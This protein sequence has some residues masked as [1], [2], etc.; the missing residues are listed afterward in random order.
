MKMLGGDWSRGDVLAFIGVLV[1]ILGIWIAHRDTVTSGAKLPSE[2]H[3]STAG[4]GGASGKTAGM[5]HPAIKIVHRVADVSS[6]QVN[7]GC[8][9]N[10]QAKT[11]EVFFGVNPAEIQARTECVQTDNVKGH[12]Q[13]VVYDK[14]PASHVRG[15]L[16]RGSITGL[17]KQF[18]NCPG[19][20]H[21][22][23]ALHV[24]WTEEQASNAT[25]P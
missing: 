7:F 20:G 9:E 6:G 24:T 3:E 13:E 12:N 2:A 23:L 22:T 5:D 21:G 19:G 15:V 4:S 25:N 17:D 16:A 11:P 8:E 14:D 10:R 18:L 1:A